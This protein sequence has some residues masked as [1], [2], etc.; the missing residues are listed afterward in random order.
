M[1]E[2]ALELQ[3]RWHGGAPWASPR[4]TLVPGVRGTR[5][6][7]EGPRCGSSALYGAA[8]RCLA[9]S[10]PRQGRGSFTAPS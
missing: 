9:R 6:W 1:Q 5:F 7:E 10:G 2:P 4:R 3:A 8:G